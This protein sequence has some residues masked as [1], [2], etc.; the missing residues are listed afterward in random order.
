MAETYHWLDVERIA[1]ELAEAYPQIDPLS[2]RFPK[3]RDMVRSLPG[4]AEQPGHPVNERILE[5]IQA[6]WNSEYRDLKQE[7]ND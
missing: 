3:L 1:E 6:L 4:F 7:D 2:V 5:T